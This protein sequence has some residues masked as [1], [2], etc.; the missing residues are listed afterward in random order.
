MSVI[1]LEYLF[2]PRSVAVIGATNDPRNAGNIVMRNLMAG[3]F[4]GPVMPVSD[5]AEAI[6]GVLTYPSVKMLPKTPDL[7]VVCSP[8]DEVPEIIHSL[9]EGGTRGAVLMGSG[10][11]GMSKE[12]RLDI[13]ATIL[14]IANPPDIRILGPK[15]LGFMVPSLNLNASLAHANATPGKVAFISQSDSLFATVLDWALAKGVGFSHMVALGSR[16]DVSFADILDYLASDPLT[17]SIM[18]YVESIKDARAFMSAARAAS[19]NKPVLVIRP[20]QALDT[21]LDEHKAWESGDHRLGDA[22][23]DVAFRR[24]GMLR[25][26]NI[27]GLFDAA[28]TL[29]TPKHVY[30]RKLAILTNGTSAG[31]LAADRL[32]AGGGELAGLA[33]ETVTA[34]DALLG[35]ENWS[36][37]NPVGI[38]FDADG[39][40]YGEVVKLLLKDKG[41]NGILVMH[42]PWT[43]QPD[44]EVATALRDALKRSQRM[45]LTAWLGSGAAVQSREI[46]SKAGIPTYDTPTHAVR[47]F[48]YM[49]EYQQNQELLIE[50]PDSLPTDFFPDT[51]RA[52]DIV[53]HALDKGRTSLTE[54]EAK[55]TLAAYGIPV[56]E[57]RIARSAKEAVI[58]ADEL[59]YPVAIKLR[60]PQIPQ[61]FDM[62]GVLLDLETPERVWEGAASILA[63]ATRE[64]PDAYIEGFTVQKMG[65]RPGAHELA[66]S[67]EVDPVFGPVLLFGHGGMAREMIQDTALTLPPLSMS[68]ARE[69]VGRTRISA[70]LKGTPSHPPADIDDISLTLI[71]LSQL[72]VDVPQIASIDIN[73]LYADSEGVLALGGKITIAPFEGDGERR[74]AIRPYPRE[75]EECVSLKSGR[76]VTIRPIRPEDE[77]THRVFLSNLTDEDL[78]LRFFGVV[79][80]DF[81]HKD[82]ARFTQIDY[83]R[84]MAFI[85]TAQDPRGEPET[86]GVMRTNTR[87]DN[88]EAEFAIVVRSDQ[89]G[90]GLG[91]L[92]FFKGIRYTKDRRT[93]QLTGQTML[94]N[95]A[96]QGLARKFG[97]VITPDPHDEDLVDMTLDMDTVKE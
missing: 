48:L 79:Q 34:I 32:L 73:P 88:S 64:R 17:R 12:E 46:F 65:R 59:G 68:L 75:L 15:S 42:V 3:G 11:S 97:F 71:Q 58:A 7:A 74:L 67:A 96:M 93:R 37:S 2:K 51:L 53:Q 21:V 50:T 86:L 25:V 20:G 4:M 92:L 82:I 36:R 22:I 80:R 55:D 60:S 35:E 91:S 9:K 70:L 44:L 52:R 72:I 81:D 69:L 90:E 1:N 8:L 31:I 27:D 76:H 41:S 38:P 45:V 49:A 13:K 18:L 95:K 6:A 66:V 54:P 29:G 14:K 77:S 26:E 40:A 30:G 47:A 85:A 10:F 61:P 43:A 63:R 5:T 23:Y 24:A 39:K 19:R 33:D 83:D 89:K 56:V 57:T 28:Q 16:I 84:E 94:E 78:R 62:G 87:P